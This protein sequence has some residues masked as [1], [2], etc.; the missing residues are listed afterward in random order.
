MRKATTNKPRTE[1]FIYQLMVL[2]LI[3]LERDGLDSPVSPIC[4]AMEKGATKRQG[5]GDLVGQCIRESLLATKL[6]RRPPSPNL[7]R[8]EE[9]PRLQTP[10]SFPVRH[11]YITKAGKR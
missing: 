11:K 9:D 6:L 7:T 10:P 1:C 2:A 4:P 5:T 3:D 8:R